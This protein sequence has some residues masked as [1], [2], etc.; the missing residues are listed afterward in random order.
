MKSEQRRKEESGY[1]VPGSED[2]MGCALWR[3][4]SWEAK[5]PKG[6]WKEATGIER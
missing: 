4:L 1:T 2:R 5:H 3:S 6:R